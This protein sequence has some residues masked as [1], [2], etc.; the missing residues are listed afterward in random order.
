MTG[1]LVFIGLGLNDEKDITLK[2]LETARDCNYVF[3]EF[4][5][6]V[7]SG[8]GIGKLETLIG[9]EITV[10]SREDVEGEKT[11]LEKAAKGKV[12]LLTAG[13]PMAATTHVSL[14]LAALKHGIDTVI[15]HNASVISAAAGALGL[16]HYK[17]GRTASIAFRSGNYKPANAYDA[18]SANLRDGLHTL[19]LLDLRPDENKF[20]TANDGIKILLDIESERK[21]GVFTGDTLV[22]AAGRLGSAKPVL[23]A[24]KVSSMVSQDF[25]PAPHCIV[26]PGKMHFMEEEA[27]AGIAGMA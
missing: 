18:I 17:F 11:I 15:I 20:M 9:K 22:C 19:V 7:L 26:V 24:G 21:G 3:A 4:Y 13:D 27:L 6:S 16:Q 8:T 25:G 10:L 12:A 14:R 1:S 5:T 2:G 23:R